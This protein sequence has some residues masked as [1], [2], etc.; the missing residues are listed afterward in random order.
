MGLVCP[1]GIKLYTVDT[2]ILRSGCEDIFILFLGSVN[3]FF[4]T[5]CITAGNSHILCMVRRLIG[6]RHICGLL[7]WGIIS[8]STSYYKLCEKRLQNN[9]H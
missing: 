6:N 2:Q 5:P 8:T 3:Y 4:F 1:V 7:L 9:K